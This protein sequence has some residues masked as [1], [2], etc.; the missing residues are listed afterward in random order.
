[1]WN[2]INLKIYDILYE[3]ANMKVKISNQLNLFNI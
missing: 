1:M 2:T 3:Q